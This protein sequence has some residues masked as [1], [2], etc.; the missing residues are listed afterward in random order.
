MQNQIFKSFKLVLETKD[1]FCVD[2]FPETLSVPSRQGLDDKR[3]V[4]GLE[5]QTYFD[6]PLFPVHR[7]DYEVS[8]LLL[9]AKNKAAHRIS[10]KWFSDHL[11][12]KTYEA[13]GVFNQ[14]L[15]AIFP[16][17]KFEDV[18]DIENC[19][20]WKCF[21]EKG[22]RRAFMHPKGK[23][24]LT[25]VKWCSRQIIDNISVD[26]F[27]LSPV[28]GRSHQLRFEMFRHQFPIIGDDLYHFAPD[29]FKDATLKSLLDLRCQN[30]G[31]ALRAISLDLAQALK[32]DPLDLP[33]QINLK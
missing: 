1:F 6:R 26:T 28:T 21:L 5:L 3:L 18:L 12:L 20:E 27:H 4:V 30:K 24:S 17:I 19:S 11:V 13:S 32:L 22:K 14:Q 2:K 8:G 25:K 29:R 16:D 33:A 7:L 9:F 10:Q 15:K 31:I 23:L